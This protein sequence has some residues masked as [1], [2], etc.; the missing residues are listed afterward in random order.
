MFD[1]MLLSHILLKLY[2]SRIY[3]G[4]YASSQLI[5]G[6]QRLVM[7]LSISKHILSSPLAL[8]LLR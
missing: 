1:F 7:S 3:V 5:G 6:A 4:K 8:T 2:N